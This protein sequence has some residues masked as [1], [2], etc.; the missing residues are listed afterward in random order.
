MATAEQLV[1]FIASNAADHVR[2]D[3][4]LDDHDRRLEKFEPGRSADP[5]KT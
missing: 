1:G 3:R 2:F 5:D 4:R